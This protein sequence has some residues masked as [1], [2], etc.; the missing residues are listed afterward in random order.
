VD[1]DLED[2]ED[3]QR[4]QDKDHHQKADKWDRVKETVSVLNFLKRV[5]P[6]FPISFSPFLNQP[7]RDL[8]F[9]LAESKDHQ[10]DVPPLLRIDLVLK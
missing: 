8:V 10:Q 6:V 1:K 2:P 4:D 9:N 7:R 3:H 5:A